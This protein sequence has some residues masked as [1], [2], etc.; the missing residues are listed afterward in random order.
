MQELLLLS[1]TAIP[2]SSIHLVLSVLA[3]LAAAQPTIYTALHLV[4]APTRIPASA[5]AATRSTIPSQSLAQ[6]K[7]AGAAGDL[8]YVQLVGRMH[9]PPERRRGE[10][11]DEREGRDGGEGEAKTDGENKATTVVDLDSHPWTLEFRDFPDA[12]KGRP[13]TSRLMASIPM[14]QGDPVAFLRAIGYEY[15][16]IQ[17]YRTRLTI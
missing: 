9:E 5:I 10:G 7:I 4:F 16:Y 13:V 15:A 17:P 11:Q 14:T 1:S 2:S 8:F 6:Q 12:G 3:G